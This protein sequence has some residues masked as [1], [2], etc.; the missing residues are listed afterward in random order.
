MH[1]LHAYCNQTLPPNALVGMLTVQRVCFLCEN[2]FAFMC[3]F[4]CALSYVYV[5]CDGCA[6]KPLRLFIHIDSRH[7]C[8]AATIPPRGRRASAGAR[9]SG[10][11]ARRNHRFASSLGTAAAA[12]GEGRYRYTHALCL[13]WY[14]FATFLNANAFPLA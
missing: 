2:I 3:D 11:S 12:H 1:L 4:F 8:G 9:A 10:A 7:R 5:C 14:T 13:I 6:H